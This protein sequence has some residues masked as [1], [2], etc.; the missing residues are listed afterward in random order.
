MR[1]FR[2]IGLA[3]FAILLCLSACSSGGDDPVEEDENEKVDFTGYTSTKLKIN[4]K[5]FWLNDKY[6]GVD[7]S[8]WGDDGQYFHFLLEGKTEDMDLITIS[9]TESL[10]LS[11]FKNTN[12]NITTYI[13]LNCIIKDNQQFFYDYV[14]G[15]ISAKVVNGTLKVNFESAIFEGV[16]W[17]SPIVEDKRNFHGEISYRF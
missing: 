13:T 12:K 8:D 7:I 5:T 11:D 1:I 2:F 6:C 3:L 9:L 16:T 15:K 10:P 4:G 17:I 14:K